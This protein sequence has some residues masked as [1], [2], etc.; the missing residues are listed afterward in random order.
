M[1]YDRKEFF[2]YVKR[3]KIINFVDE[4]MFQRTQLI[5]L[6]TITVLKRD[7]SC[8]LRPVESSVVNLV[9][10]FETILYATTTQ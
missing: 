5:K 3:A 7:V 2:L 4:M 9:Y 1:F 6:S 10:F 8:Q